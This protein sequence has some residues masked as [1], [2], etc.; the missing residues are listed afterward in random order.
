QS[1]RLIGSLG[2]IL[3]QGVITD[4]NAAAQYLPSVATQQARQ[5]LL[6]SGP[7]LATRMKRAMVGLPFKTGIFDPFLR[8]VEAARTQPPLT[9]KS[10]ASSALGLRL[11]SL[12]F[13]SEGRWVAP[14]LLHGVT[15]AERL[16]TLA[17]KRDGVETLYLDL[18][19]E[20]TRIMGEVIDR[21]MVLLAWGGLLIYVVLAVYFRSPWKP[22]RILG[23]TLAAVLAV[24]TLLVFS[25]TPLTLFHLV[26]LLLVI[27]LG[28]DYA[29]FYN[30]LVENQDEWSTTFK[31]L[32]VCCVTTVLVFGALLLSST[33]PLQAIGMT[34]ALGAGFC[35][36]FGAIW[37]S[38]PRL[39]RSTRLSV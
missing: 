30:R 10:L 29:L 25:N 32:W 6:P 37:S 5:A 14:I 20:S 22:L 21:V 39:M 16:K 11:Q 26:S 31:A 17:G 4:F 9:P 34:V 7:E 33:P 28:L 8:D 19:G 1:E 2:E 3:P 38:A 12:L 27:G 24:S 15:N 35:L 13:E 18:K 23:P 36:V